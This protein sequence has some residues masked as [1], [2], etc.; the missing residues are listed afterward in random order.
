MSFTPEHALVWVE[1]PVRDL[2]RGMAFYSKVFDYDLQKD[3][4]GPNPMAMLPVTSME[5][6]VAGHLYPGE[7]ANG[8]NGPTF[9]LQVPDTLEAAGE[10]CTAA[11]GRLVSD[12][13]PMPF[14]RFQ[15]ATDPDGNSMGLF[16]P[17]KAA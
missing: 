15:Y 1:I 4:S 7:P 11:G 14:G 2:D 8:G 17:A 9:H 6:G 3:E 13:I 10:R 12:P 16:E 5:S